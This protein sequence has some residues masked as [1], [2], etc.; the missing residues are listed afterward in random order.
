[1][2]FGLKDLKDSVHSLRREKVAGGV[3]NWEDLGLEWR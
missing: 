1:M 3:G 2:I